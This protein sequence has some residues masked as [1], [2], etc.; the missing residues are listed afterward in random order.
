VARG[1]AS[2]ALPLVRC[3]HAALDTAQSGDYSNWLVTWFEVDREPMPARAC[4]SGR[5]TRLA[6]AVSPPRHHATCHRPA[7]DSRT[8]R[9]LASRPQRANGLRASRR[10]VECMYLHVP[11]RRPCR[12]RLSAPSRSRSSSTRRPPLMRTRPPFRTARG[13]NGSDVSDRP[14]RCQS[15]GGSTYDQ[16]CRTQ[17]AARHMRSAW[18]RGS[19]GYEWRE[20]HVR[21]SGRTGRGWS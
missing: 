14:I 17:N 8:A 12:L 1:G 3:V 6:P 7:D 2:V 11:R 4:N 16:D 21:Q 15:E 10:H 18:V 9:A 19:G 20:T 13:E 5:G